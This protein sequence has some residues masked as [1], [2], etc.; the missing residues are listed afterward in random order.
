MKTLPVKCTSRTCNG[1][2]ISFEYVKDQNYLNGEKLY[3]LYRCPVCS[4]EEGFYFTDF[5]INLM[6]LKR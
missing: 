4:R 2:T 5:Y 1:K 6:G 3:E